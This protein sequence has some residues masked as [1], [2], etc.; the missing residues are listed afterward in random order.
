MTGTRT[1]LDSNPVGTT[2][3]DAAEGADQPEGETLRAS[4][5]GENRSTA[6][7]LFGIVFVMLAS[8]VGIVFLVLHFEAIHALSKP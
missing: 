1:P 3:G 2:E 8:A 6:L 5:P 7:T 4:L